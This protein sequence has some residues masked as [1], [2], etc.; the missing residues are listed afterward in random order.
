MNDKPE[1]LREIARTIEIDGLETNYLEIGKGDTLV[2]LHGGEF[3]ASAELCWEENI[4]E[5]SSHFRVIAPD[6][7]GFGK[8][9]KVHDFV[10]GKERR[11]RHMSQFCRA[12]DVDDAVFVGNSMGG[13]MLLA[14]AASASPLLPARKIISVCGGGTMA[15]NDSV[16]AL[17]AYD[18]SFE[19]MERLLGALFH[20]EYWRSDRSYI[21]RRHSASIQPGAWEAVAAA[22]F[23]RPTAAAAKESSRRPDYRAIDVPVLIVA[24]NQDKLKPRGWARELASDVPGA[25]YVDIDDAGHCPQIEQPDRFHRVL[26]DFIES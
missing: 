15:K 5:L 13:A 10:D 24:G 9:A 14:D 11:L 20:G 23:R 22:R 1:R 2:L 3:G 25:T 7:L 26:L 12:V 6:W 4:F 16:D 18:G 19:A 17:F 21:R 8:T